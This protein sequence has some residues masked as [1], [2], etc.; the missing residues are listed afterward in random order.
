MRE[1]QH[2]KGVKCTDNREDGNGVVK[3]SI[4]AREGVEWQ[5]E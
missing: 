4:G 5:G 1:R 2:G 3:G